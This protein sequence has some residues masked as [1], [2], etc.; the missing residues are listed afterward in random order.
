MVI[1]VYREPTVHRPYAIYF[2]QLLNLCLPQFSSF[3]RGESC[4]IWLLWGLNEV[5]CIKCLEQ[6]PAQ[7]KCYTRVCYH[8]LRF[9]VT[10]WRA[11]TYPHHFKD[12]LTEAQGGKGNWSRSK[13]WQV[14]DWCPYV[15]GCKAWLCFSYWPLVPSR[16][17]ECLF[18]ITQMHMSSFVALK[19]CS[20]C[21]QVYQRAHV[22]EHTHTHTLRSIVFALSIHSEQWL[23]SS[24]KL[25]CCL[26]I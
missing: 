9:P 23:L 1:T 4:L 12:E 21:L 5:M 24:Q 2:G 22:H 14:A 19:C 15:S 16:S 25:Y 11:K 26:C 3:A 20:H 6:R 10:T 7:N 8:N 13:G 18:E 17:T